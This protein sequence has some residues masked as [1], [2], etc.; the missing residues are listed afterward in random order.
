MAVLVEC[1]CHK[2]QSLRNKVCSCGED[3]VKA[4]RGRQG[5]LLDHLSPSRGQTEEGTCRG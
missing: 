4:K 2:K 1:F 5:Q 3:L